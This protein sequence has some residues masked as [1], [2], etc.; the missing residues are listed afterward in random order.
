MKK[1]MLSLLMQFAICFLASF[2]MYLLKPV[3]VL[4]DI[5][6]Y[7]CFPLF[8]L[9]GACIVVGRGVNPYAAWLLPPVAETLSGFLASMGY[10]PGFLS[11]LITAFASLIGAAAGDVINKQ[12]KRR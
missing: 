3:P 1:R 5:L 7:A 9:I 11:I 10:A 4:F 8:S 6:L 12:G 2:L